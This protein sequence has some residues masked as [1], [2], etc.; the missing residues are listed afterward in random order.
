MNE[1]EEEQLRQAAAGWF[2]RMRGPQA[3]AHRDAFEAWRADPAHADA[4][5]RMARRWDDSAVLGA[6]Q[7][8]NLRLVRT[9]PR[10]AGL[11]GGAVAAIAAG[12]V[13]LVAGAAWVTMERTRHGL[14]GARDY[15]SGVGEIRT[16][17]LEQGRTLILDTDSRVRR[18]RPDG[19]AA[20]RLD[21]GRV[22][23]VA[24]S[25]S[26]RV[27]LQ[28]AMLDLRDG[29]VDLARIEGGFDITA[30][31]AAVEVRPRRNGAASIHLAAGQ[32]LTLVG[33]RLTGPGPARAGA[34]DWPSGLA[35]F[36]GA[37]LA[38]VL[39]QASRYGGPKIRLADPGLAGLQVSGAFKI[40]RSEPLARAL[41]VAFK[42]Q[43]DTAPNGD[44]VLS[45]TTT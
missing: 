2:A 12:L 43:V 30:V 38:D 10:R 9:P 18:V 14:L 34:R 8:P 17:G 27:D 15:A 40:T 44:L 25:Q 36:D 23:V 39:A 21:Q 37:R 24:A 11:P 26:V 41:A 5:A 28:D 32:R 6:S 13:V 4:Y 22:R 16:V 1:I 31:S 35:S 33:G 45:R 29:A 19:E 7:L 42:L 3:S 20:L